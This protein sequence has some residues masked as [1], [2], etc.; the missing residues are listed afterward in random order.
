[1]IQI[2]IHEEVAEVSFSMSDV[3]VAALSL[4]LLIFFGVLGA[5]V[6]SRGII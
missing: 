6:T 4:F 3:A 5:I 2:K 1:M